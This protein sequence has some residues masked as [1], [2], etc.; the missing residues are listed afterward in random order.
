MILL[1][2]APYKITAYDYIDS[3][4]PRDQSMILLTLAPHKITVYDY[5]D[6]GTPQDHSPCHRF[7]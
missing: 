1:T 5:T 7:Y 6:S 4:T 3:G 2:L